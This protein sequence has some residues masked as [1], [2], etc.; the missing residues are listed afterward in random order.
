MHARHARPWAV[1]LV[2]LV[3][4][5][6]GVV[7]LGYHLSEL[8]STPMDAAHAWVLLLRA[9][10]VGIAVGLLRGTRLSRWLAIA[11]MAYHTGLS[12]FHSATETATHAA[13]L[14]VIA[15]LLFVPRSSAF[16][17]TRAGEGSGH[18]A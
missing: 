17:R 11:W 5:A 18:R 15:A 13:L 8:A 16:F 4:C 9:V 2:A 6:A 14:V 3:F 7:G 12:A 1:T 10:A